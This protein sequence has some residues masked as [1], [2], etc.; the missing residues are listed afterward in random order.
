[1]R[2]TRS[3]GAIVLAAWLILTGL[4]LLTTKAISP[5][6]MGVLAIASGVLFLLSR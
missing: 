1:M 4:I 6:V 2:L 3:I 5:V